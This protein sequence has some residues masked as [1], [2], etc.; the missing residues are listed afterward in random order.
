MSVVWSK[1]IQYILTLDFYTLHVTHSKSKF[2]STKYNNRYSYDQI[3][4]QCQEI[5][6]HSSLSMS[7]KSHVALILIWIF[8]LWFEQPLTYLAITNEWMKSSRLSNNDLA[9]LI[10]P[11]WVQCVLDTK[12]EGK[13]CEQAHCCFECIFA[14]SFSLL[15]HT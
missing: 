3:Q 15:L 12:H 11:S 8:G 5:E 14:P 6:V 1:L 4:G 13:H 10:R 2:R 9:I 7:K